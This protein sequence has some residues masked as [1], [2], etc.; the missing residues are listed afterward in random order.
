MLKERF[1]SAIILLSLFQA[2]LTQIQSLEYLLPDAV[3]VEHVMTKRWED[4]F[5]VFVS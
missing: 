2:A 1:P 4:E 5:L 3:N